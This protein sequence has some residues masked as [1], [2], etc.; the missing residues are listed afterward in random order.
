MMC[1]IVLHNSNWSLTV[2]AKGSWYVIITHRNSTGPAQWILHLQNMTECQKHHQLCRWS[3]KQP[4]I[5]CEQPQGQVQW[6]RCFCLTV[7]NGMHH[8]VNCMPYGAKCEGCLLSP[9]QVVAF[10]YNGKPLPHIMK[11]PNW[12]VNLYPLIINNMNQH[13]HVIILFVKSPRIIAGVCLY[14]WCFNRYYISLAGTW[15]LHNDDK[16]ESNLF[17]FTVFFFMSGDVV[18]YRCLPGYTLVGKA[19]LTCK[20]NS[21]LLFEAP[22]PTCQGKARLCCYLNSP[23]LPQTKLLLVFF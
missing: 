10:Y 23:P 20:L 4:D 19:E 2:K 14:L 22:P 7:L 21:H 12:H 16:I 13:F 9:W 11:Q 1:Y 18:K 5:N 6:C 15:S 8:S 3:A 17:S